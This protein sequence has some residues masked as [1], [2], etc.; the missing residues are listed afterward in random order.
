MYVWRLWQCCF[1]LKTEI[2]KTHTKQNATII[3]KYGNLQNVERI[4]LLG[5]WASKTLQPC[6]MLR[7]FYQDPAT[8]AT[9]AFFRGSYGRRKAGVLRSLFRAGVRG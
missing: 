9:S 1:A 7:G 6:T 5:A 8:D 2:L 4:M 3:F